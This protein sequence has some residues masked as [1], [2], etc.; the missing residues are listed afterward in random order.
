MSQG[1]NRQRQGGEQN[2]ALT[3]G[4]VLV[5]IPEPQFKNDQD[6]GTIPK[7]KTTTYITFETA[8]LQATEWPVNERKWPLSTKSHLSTLHFDNPHIVFYHCS[9]GLFIHFEQT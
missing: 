5:W 6:N 4:Q 9:V 2:S 8:I 7:G 3:P 1:V